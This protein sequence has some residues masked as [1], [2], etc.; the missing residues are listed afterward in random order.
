MGKYISVIKP[1]TAEA[2]TIIQDGGEMWKISIKPLFTNRLQN[3]NYNDI[4][5]EYNIST[6]K[7]RQVSKKR[8]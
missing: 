5:K 3:Q 1:A 4:T 7:K 6:V 2:Y 8:R